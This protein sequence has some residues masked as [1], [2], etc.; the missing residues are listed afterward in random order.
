MKLILVSLVL[1]VLV[2]VCVIEWYGMFWLVCRCI[3]GCGCFLFLV[4]KWVVVLVWV[5]GLLF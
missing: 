2:S 1:D 5:I 3:L 4:L